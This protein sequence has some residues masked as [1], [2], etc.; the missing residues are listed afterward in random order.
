MA[1][2]V[3]KEIYQGKRT[4]CLKCKK[5][6]KHGDETIV[7]RR[8]HGTGVAARFCSHKCQNEKFDDIMSR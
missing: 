5:Q 6:I 7:V 3:T 1:Q 2:I 8:K 4:K